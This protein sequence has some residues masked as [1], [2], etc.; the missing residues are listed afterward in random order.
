MARSAESVTPRSGLGPQRLP[1]GYDIIRLR[2]N[3]HAPRNGI[4]F[5]KVR[6]QV[7]SDQRTMVASRAPTTTE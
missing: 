5:Q 4:H 1:L 3:S 6:V 2:S 7:F